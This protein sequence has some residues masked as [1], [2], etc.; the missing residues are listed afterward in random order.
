M[1]EVFDA[2][3]VTG[4]DRYAAQGFVDHHNPFL[5]QAQGLGGFRWFCAMFVAAFPDA[6]WMVEDEIAKGDKVVNR[7][8]TRGTHRG[9][10]MGIPPTGKQVTMSGI[11]IICACG[12]RRCR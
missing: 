9:A 8:T 7:A 1:A 6:E 4:A 3:N 5:S 12:P 11:D 10:F 2:K